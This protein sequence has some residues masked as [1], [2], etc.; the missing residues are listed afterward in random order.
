MVK[1]SS[2][3]PAVKPITDP[4]VGNRAPEVAPAEVQA[5]DAPVA[6]PLS[7]EVKSLVD[8]AVKKYSDA[9]NRRTD[10]TPESKARAI[11]KYTAR[12]ISQMPGMIAAAA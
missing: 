3:A 12:M 8:A 9:M 11:A 1:Q 4:I 6:A 7:P 2:N 10:M 5:P